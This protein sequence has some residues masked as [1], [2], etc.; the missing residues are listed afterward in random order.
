[1]SDVRRAWSKD[2]S[3]AEIA[4]FLANS[5][6]ANQIAAQHDS[7]TLR[8]FSLKLLMEYT[9]ARSGVLFFSDR[10]SG[11]LIPK[12]IRGYGEQ[13]LRQ[14]PV[15]YP[16]QQIAR[17]TLEKQQPLHVKDLTSTSDWLAGLEIFTNGVTESL[18]AAPLFAGNT[19]FGMVLLVNPQPVPEFLF[20]LLTNRLATE[21]ER[22]ARM[23]AQQTRVNR[24]NALIAVLGQLGANLDRGQILRMVINYAPVLLNAEASSLFLID[25]DN[26]DLFLYHASNNQT[27]NGSEIRIPAGKGIVGEV[28]K[29]G[30]A[31]IV[32]NVKKDQRHFTE[33]D[34]NTGFVT[35]S[36]LAV[37]LTTRVITLG[38][39]RRS[40][41]VRT[42]GGMEVLNKL[43]GPFTEE[44]VQLFRSLA[45]QAATGLAIADIHDDAEKLLEGVLEA[46]AAAID[47]KDPYT[48]DH[49]KR[50]RDFSMEIARELGYLDQLDNQGIDHYRQ[51]WIGSL[52]HDI[53][54]IGIPD[55]ILGKE[56]RLT[57][58][59]Y[60]QI[61]QHPI[62][63]RHI[64]EQVP[65]LRDGLAAIA[66][67]HEHL[68]GSGYPFQLMDDQISLTAR[69]VAVADVFDAMTSDRPYR[70]A[71]PVQEVFEY[72][73]EVADKHLDGECVEALI[74]AYR[75]GRIHSQKMRELAQTRPLRSPS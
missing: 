24:L 18:L 60:L 2:L 29:T 59:E 42:I 21:L 39:E 45:N 11:Q 14:F 67:H 66:Q 34:E 41:T 71:L 10:Y 57:P 69:I 53:G 25:P 32:N 74:R 37:P 73:R 47:A 48:Q 22:A 50:V 64:L 36:I 75:A 49:S 44:D 43:D 62:I 12:T 55:I 35:R 13:D 58:Q 27:L 40:T 63:G 7:Y 20:Q 46:L 28:V 61:K 65:Q 70:H 38:S 6:R 68:D 9:G 51:I 1:M 56:G 16:D 30:Q 26:E 54:K 8:Q 72:M 17:K 31:I 23:D 52:L 33:V 5:E 3:Q 19:T 15:L 4:E